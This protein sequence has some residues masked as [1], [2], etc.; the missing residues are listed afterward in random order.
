M[1]GKFLTPSVF[2]CDRL[3]LRGEKA[4]VAEIPAT[5]QTNLLHS[6]CPLPDP[7]V[8]EHNDVFAGCGTTVLGSWKRERSRAHCCFDLTLTVNSYVN[9]HSY[10]KN[11]C[12]I[13]HSNPIHVKSQR[14][15][16]EGGNTNLLKQREK[17]TFYAD[18][19][20]MFSR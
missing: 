18:D 8:N 17:K 3:V 11:I 16:T 12:I 4:G 7:K 2:L 20:I 19:K 9:A 1:V 15:G 5:P 13:I 10:L 14:H 6:F